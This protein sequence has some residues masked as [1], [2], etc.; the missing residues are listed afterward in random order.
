MKSVLARAALPTSSGDAAIASAR[1]LPN[2]MRQAHHNHMPMPTV[3]S[4][5]LLRSTAEVLNLPASTLRF[6]I[7]NEALYTFTHYSQGFLEM[8][9]CRIENAVF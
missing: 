4:A 8:R 5:P 1:A 2:L 3:N 7:G 6:V 9:G